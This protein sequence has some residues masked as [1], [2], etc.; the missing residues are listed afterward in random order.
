MKF[1]GRGFVSVL[2]A[3]AFAVL[4]LS[5]VILYV[6]PRG[7]VANWTG[8]TM[9]ALD[10]Q[11]WQSLHINLSLLFLAATGFHLWLNWAVFWHYLKR[12]FGKGAGMKAEVLIG[13][14]LVSVFAVGAIAQWPPFSTIMLWNEQ[15]KDYWE[16]PAEQAPI[17]HAEELTLEQFAARLN[18]SGDELLAALRA[19]G[20]PVEGTG[21]T[22]AEI[23]R[24]NGRTPR[25][26]FAAIEKHAPNATEP[27]GQEQGRGRGQGGQ[28]RAGQGMGQG[29]GQGAG[30]GMGQGMGRGAGRGM[31]DG[32]GPGAGSGG[33]R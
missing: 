4:V 28:Q 21:Q 27:A 14:A 19:E 11:Q 23:A 17:P 25:E 13:L 3:L 6:T 22:I 2:L 12:A 8:W 5:G 10:K 29:M 33:G 18:L 32:M 15:I 26:V 9:L 24:A 20:I 16:R 31:G 1:S 30:R 7:R